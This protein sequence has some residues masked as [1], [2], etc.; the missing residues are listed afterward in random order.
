MPQLPTLD[1]AG[2]TT[3]E[4][5]GCKDT[6]STLSLVFAFEWGL[7][8]KA[9]LSG[10]AAL[11]P[12]ERLVL[13]VLALDREVNNG[14]FHQFFV[15]SSSRFTPIVVESLLRLDCHEAAAITQRAIAALQLN[16]LSVR[17]ISKT[18]C[19]DDA[20]RDALLDACDQAFYKLDGVHEKLFQFIEQHQ[21]QIQLVRTTDYPRPFVVHQLSVASKLHVA[22]LA[23]RLQNKGWNP[24]LEQARVV[25]EELSRNRR[26]S[27]TATDIEAAAILFVFARSIRAGALETAES[28]APRAFALMREDPHYV[29]AQRDWVRLL[30]QSARLGMADAALLQYLEYLKECDPS[31]ERAQNYLD[32]WLPVLQPHRAAL[33]K[34]IEFFTANFPQVDLHKPASPR[35]IFRPN[36]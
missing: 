26:F 33:P 11:T 27:S 3:P 14:G 32:F 7:Q 8:A 24:D 34:S 28:L 29:I 4:I 23:H 9:R 31:A 16:A 18:I 19:R 21:Q 17:S 36:P 12:E 6:H 1:Y 2:Q 35:K 5:L 15:N 22:L 25:A 20:S 13:A 10:E 30:I